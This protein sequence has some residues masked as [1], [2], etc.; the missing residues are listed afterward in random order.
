MVRV[1]CSGVL[2]WSKRTCASFFCGLFQLP[3]LDRKLGEAADATDECDGDGELKVAAAFNGLE[4]GSPE[5]VVDGGG[6]DK[7]GL[8]RADL[9]E[10][11]ED[12][13]ALGGVQGRTIVH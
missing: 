2:R 5:D 10:D 11:F 3:R 6:A 1:T 12:G 13:A 4:V 8:E 7:F 9:I